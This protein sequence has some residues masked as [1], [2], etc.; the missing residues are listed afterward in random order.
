MRNSLIER[1]SIHEAGHAVAALAFGI[2]II[3]VS[4]TDDTP[5]LH[6]GR[7]GGSYLGVP[8]LA[9]F[10]LISGVSHKT[11]FNRE[12]RISSFPLYSI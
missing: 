3:A 4:I 2:P 7:A 5:H 11:T 10:F 8:L 1:I 6:R 9:S 12:L